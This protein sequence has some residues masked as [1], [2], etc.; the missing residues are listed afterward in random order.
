MVF[1]KK[2]NL[3]LCEPCIGHG[4]ALFLI[5]TGIL[6]MAEDLGWVNFGISMWPLFLILFGVYHL[7]NSDY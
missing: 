7:I 4:F 6:W 5:S 3:K 1:R 2:A